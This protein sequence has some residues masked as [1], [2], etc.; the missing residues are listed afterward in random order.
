[1]IIFLKN[2]INQIYV[3]GFNVFSFKIKKF[4]FTIFFL[5][6]AV[7]FIPFFIII[8]I[9]SNFFLVRFGSL[10]SNRIGHF[11]NDVNLYICDIKKSN[12]KLDIFYLEKPVCNYEL[13]KL[14][15]N[16]LFIF[17]KLFII[18]F[19]MLNRIKFLGNTKHNI[20][21]TRITGRN[22]SNRDILNNNYHFN[23]KDIFYGKSFLRSLGL[24]E[25]DKF[26]CLAVR[27]STYLKFHQPYANFDYQNYRDCNIENF[28]LVSDYLTSLGYYVFRMGAKV[29]KP[30]STK[31][32][33]I[34]DYA[35]TGIRNEFLDIYL[36]AYCEFCISTSLGFDSLPE[37]FNKPLV[38]VS[39][40]PI[41]HIRSTNKKHL[42]IFRHHLDIINKKPITLSQIFERNIADALHSRVYTNKGV[43]LIENT[44][45]EIKEA[46]IEMLNLMKNNF[47]KDTLQDS[48][49]LK[50]WSLFNDKI[51]KY[52]F[53]DIHANFFKAHIGENFL[54]KNI[55]FLN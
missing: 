33:K 18:P 55:N 34:I 24:N 21:L 37:M 1:V 49:E 35:T 10:P 46:T 15:K 31:N 45:E 48:L 7:F 54:K 3:G 25:D 2:Q 8:R 29:A 30:M 44:P 26:V 11:V 28:K 19:V 20:V 9:I 40:A 22:L 42:S 52:G 23:N 27:D 13:V 43:N 12:L 51:R 14:F 5:L 36:S 50:F 17:P 41:A 47:L 32:K 38:V 53:K 6:I 39:V 16:Y 4:F